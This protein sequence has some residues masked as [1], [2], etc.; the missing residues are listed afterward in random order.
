M[1]LLTLKQDDKD[2]YG[3]YVSILCDKNKKTLLDKFIDLNIELNEKIEPSSYHCTIIC[4]HIQI[5]SAE[6]LIVPQNIIA[7][8]TGYD[9]LT[10][11]T[12]GKCLV[13]ILNCHEASRLNKLLIQHGAISDFDDYKPHITICYNYVGNGNLTKLPI[14]KF[15]IIFDQYEVKSLDQNFIPQKK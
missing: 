14:P 13:M 8:A 11:K 6:T 12:G 3:T 7:Y 5:P 9:L 15:D 10:T 2:K 4:S 1:S